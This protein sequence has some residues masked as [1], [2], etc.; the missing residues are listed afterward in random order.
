MIFG[1]KLYDKS[2]RSASIIIFKYWRRRVYGKIFF[3]KQLQ[4]W[5]NFMS[6]ERVNRERERRDKNYKDYIAGY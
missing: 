2:D 5:L 4:H 1:W 3:F 6:R